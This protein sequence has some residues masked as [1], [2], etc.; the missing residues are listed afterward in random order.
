MKLVSCFS[1]FCLRLFIA[2]GLLLL[3]GCSSIPA[4]QQ[5]YVSKAGMVNSDSMLES[6]RVNLMSQIEPGNSVSG[7]AQAAGCT[8]CR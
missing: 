4:Y 1:M 3:V 7:G 6:S 8:A 2:F 5:E